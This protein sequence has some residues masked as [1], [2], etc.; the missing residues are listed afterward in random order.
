[1]DSEKAETKT[2]VHHFVIAADDAESIT[3]DWLRSIGF[4]QSRPC[5][6]WG[7]PNCNWWNGEVEIWDFND[8]G[9]WLWVE[10]DSVPMRT[11]FDLRLLLEWVKAR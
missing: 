7:T 11:R 10:F 4:E 5:H 8:T 2:P 1:M 3:H 6:V 9:E